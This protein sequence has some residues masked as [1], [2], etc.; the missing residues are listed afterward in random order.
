MVHDQADFLP[1]LIV[2]LQ[3]GTPLFSGSGIQCFNTFLRFI[4][5]RHFDESKAAGT[6]GKLIGDHPRR[7]N[8]P[9]S[10]KDFLKLRVGDGQDPVATIPSAIS[11]PSTGNAG[12]ETRAESHSHISR[13]DRAALQ[14][15]RDLLAD[16]LERTRAA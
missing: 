13:F 7:F 2:L 3:P 5:I 6:A 16:A 14:T 12:E 15:I 10:R 4:G 1:G 9:M 8:L 11:V